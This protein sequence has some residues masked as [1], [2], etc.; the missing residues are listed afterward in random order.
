M[1]NMGPDSWWD[2]HFQPAGKSAGFDYVSF[3]GTVV[4]DVKE[5][6]QGLRGLY[7]GVMQLALAVEKEPSL[8]WACLVV[9][10]AGLSLDR[11]GSEWKNILQLFRDDISRRL[12][13]VAL[14]VQNS[15]TEPPH[16]PF[17]NQIRSAFLRSAHRAAQE[18]V[19]RTRPVAG[20]RYFEIVKVLLN[21]WLRNEGLISI[22]QLAK[23]VGCTYPT[24]RVALRRLESKK[25][26]NRQSG[27]LVQL[28]RFPQEPWRE[29]V[30]LAPSMRR[31]L[32][33]VDKSGEK[34]NPN[35]LLDRLKKM[36]PKRVALGGVVAARHW[37]PEF[38][39]HGT[40]RL[41]L[42]VHAPNGAAD[43]RFL[44][45]LDPALKQTDDPDDSPA[46]VI[47]PLI[48]SAAMFTESKPNELAIA[49]PV[50]TVLDLQELG[51]AQQANQLLAHF[52][53]EIRQP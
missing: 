15:W 37:N 25:C 18:R 51:L 47:H 40:P 48:R 9:N 13:L 43:L 53:K 30:A 4:V 38:D 3:D 14:G 21:R 44:N 26:L 20:Q 42:V 50:E 29:M 19:V 23:E 41:D 6:P 31:S 24:I 46:I 10:T 11:I 33:F 49:D 22:G 8:K 52:R 39:L 45:R 12:A 32:R 2:E 35:R 7:A 28:T 34:P 17:I 27:R 5:R 36:N 16:E 1:K